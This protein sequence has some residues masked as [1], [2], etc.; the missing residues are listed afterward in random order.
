MALESQADFTGFGP[1]MDR[2]KAIHHATTRD[3]GQ[4]F[5]DATQL[6]A[7]NSRAAAET[8]LKTLQ[9]AYFTDGRL[10]YMTNN[11]LKFAII[12]DPAFTK[13]YV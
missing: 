13:P 4:N 5:L 11:D 2:R 9:P 1:V 12:S 8:Y 7:L 10:N 6:A 3:R